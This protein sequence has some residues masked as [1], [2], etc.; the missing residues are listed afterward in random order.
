MATHKERLEWMA[1]IAEELLDRVVDLE[2]D[3]VDKY[4]FGRQR[5]L[6]LA[7]IQKEKDIFSLRIQ[8]ILDNRMEGADG[9]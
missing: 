3:I 2:T 5:N 8:K 9:D 6:D 1:A 4:S 7:D